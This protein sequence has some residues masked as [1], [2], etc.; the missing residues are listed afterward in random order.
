MNSGND[1]SSKGKD[2]IENLAVQI[3]KEAAARTAEDAGDGT[4]T[5]IVIA[6]NIYNNGI[7][8]RAAG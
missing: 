2:E 4:T 1:K 5:A 6:Q 8:M 7:K 3:I